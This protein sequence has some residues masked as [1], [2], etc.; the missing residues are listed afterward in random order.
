MDVYWFEQSAADLPIDDEWL[1]VAEREQSAAM[2]I[3][4]RR[5]DWLL[6]R[7]TAKRI[8]GIRLGLPPTLAFLA[9]IEL[10][11]ASSGAPIL[12]IDGRP[13][14]FSVSLSHSSGRS[15]C[16]VASDQ[17]LLGCDLEVVE[18]RSDAFLSDYFTEQEQALVREVPEPE[19]WVRLALLW[20]AK[21]SA[22]KALQLGLRADT[23]AVS[24]CLGPISSANGRWA[25]FQAVCEDGR[26]LDG[27]WSHDEKFV[28]TLVAAPSPFLPI[29]IDCA[30]R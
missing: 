3:A 13:A 26:H 28:K 10:R 18:T 7:W 23:R 29:E 9:R 6:G 25:S 12:F 17:A 1:S 22:L 19:R 16:A 4:K 15:V 5:G 24:V 30:T 21:E 8:V 2:R 27:F 20:S 14:A 11:A